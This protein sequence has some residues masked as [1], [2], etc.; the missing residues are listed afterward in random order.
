MKF[1]LNSIS[2]FVL[3]C[4]LSF[5]SCKQPQAPQY[6]GLE[7]FKVN[8]L[9]VGE[10][11]VSADLKYFNPNHFTMKLK[12]GEMDVYINNR[13]VGKTLL[14][15]MTFIPARDSFLIPVSMKVDMKQIYSNAL[16]I[17][18]THEATIK[19][20][21]FAKLGKAGLYFDVP[22]KYE[23]KQNIEISLN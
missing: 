15:T 3:F 1:F 2:V 18:L 5:I 13:F 17:L 20:D 4:L 14:D 19:L 10:S 16:D 9:G 22:I 6:G 23:G 21:G 7:N 11:A 8:T 12:Y